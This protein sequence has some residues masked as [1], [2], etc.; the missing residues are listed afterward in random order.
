M[1]LD[2]HVYGYIACRPDHHHHLSCQRCGRVQEIGESYVAPVAR[3][4]E[5]DLGFRIDDARLDFYGVCAACMA[6]VSA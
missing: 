6:A 4:I 1:E 5:G 2:G 3:R